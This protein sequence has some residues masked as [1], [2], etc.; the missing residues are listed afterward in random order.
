L[1]SNQLR[2]WPRDDRHDL[3]VGELAPFH[4]SPGTHFA[5]AQFAPVTVLRRSA[6]GALRLGLRARYPRPAKHDR[7]GEGLVRRELLL[8]IEVVASVPVQPAR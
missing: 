7:R 4:R 5:R 3:L 6:L 8:E 2:A 1:A